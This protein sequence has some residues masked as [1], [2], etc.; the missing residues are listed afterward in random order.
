MLAAPLVMIFVPFECFIDM[1]EP[2]SNDKET[3][4]KG[5]TLR[6]IGGGGYK[7]QELRLVP[8]PILFSLITW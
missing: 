1:S 7:I 8:V 5:G 2:Y 4:E 3:G 6:G